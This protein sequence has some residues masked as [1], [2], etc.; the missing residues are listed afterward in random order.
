MDQDLYD[1]SKIV[2]TNSF[3]LKEGENLLVVVDKDT[4]PIAQA[5]ARASKDINAYTDIY[6]LAEGCRPYTGLSDPL[7][8]MIR[9]SDVMV[10]MMRGIPE[11]KQFRWLMI[12][13]GNRYGRM[14]MAPNLTIDMMKRMKNTDYEK[15]KQVGDKVKDLLKQGKTVKITSETGTD[16]TF[17]LRKDKPIVEFTGK[18]APDLVYS[19]LPI[20]RMYTGIST[21]TLSGKLVYDIFDDY[22]EQ[23]KA[24]FEKGYLE[25][26]SSEGAQHIL[27]IIKEDKTARTVAEFSI[28]LNSAALRDSNMIE[29]FHSEGVVMIGIGD[30]MGVGDN[31]SDHHYIIIMKH[32]D[33]FI[34]GK[35]IVKKGV[36]SL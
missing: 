25:N 32:A 7:V 5:M 28:G 33:V 18:I 24:L 35:Q 6:L 4:L 36:L 14:W 1:A 22:V 20:G 27:D 13:K 8:E 16:L 30:S 21:E 15:V 17:D 34:D 10:Y 19:N 31:K 29:A 3:E 9:F 26:V 12:R 2:L 11:E 23:G